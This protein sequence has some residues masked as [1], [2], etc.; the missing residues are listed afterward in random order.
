MGR[1][2]GGERRVHHCRKA[3]VTGNEG[4]CEIVWPGQVSLAIQGSGRNT[5]SASIST[6][7]RRCAWLLRSEPISREDAAAS[8]LECVR[9]QCRALKARARLLL[10]LLLGEEGPREGAGRLKESERVR[11]GAYIV[12]VAA[13]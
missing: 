4:E 8:A 7:R 9:A 6:T 1:I 13:S 3:T 10:L 2:G 12:A 5:L 11:R